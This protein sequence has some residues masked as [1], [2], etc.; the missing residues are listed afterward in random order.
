MSR[1]VEEEEETVRTGG[2]RGMVVMDG[3]QG[4]HERGSGLD[5]LLHPRRLDCGGGL[6]SVFLQLIL[7]PNLLG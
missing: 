1:T 7:I 5:N 6:M 3:L 4:G 2:V